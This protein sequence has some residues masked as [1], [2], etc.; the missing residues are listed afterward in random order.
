MAMGAVGVYAQKP[1][2]VE[3]KM[4]ASVE[5]H[6]EAN[7]AFLRQLV[8]INSGTQNLEGVRAVG[9]ELEPRFQAL[10]FTTHWVDQSAVHRAGHLLAEHLCPKPGTCGKRILLIGHMDTVFEKTSPF[11]HMTIE[12]SK[13]IGPGV[14]DMKGGLVVML[15]AL[16]AMQDAGVLQHAEITAVLDGDEESHG[17]PASISRATLVDAGKH[18]DVALEFEATAIQHG[19]YYGSISRRGTTS[20]KLTTSGKTGHSAGIFNAEMGDGAIYEIAR[21][22]NA[23]R[24]ELP[25]QYLTY[26]VGI[27]SGGTRVE[28]V[29]GGG[30]QAFGKGNVVPPIAEA[31]GDIRTLS[32]EQTARVEQKMR[33]IVAKHLPKTDGTIEF[34][35]G[36][37]AMPPTE[38]S[39]A[40][41]K[42]LNQVNATLGQ[43][44]MPELDPMQRGAGDIAF[45]ANLPGLA[46]VGATGWDSHAPGESADLPSQSLN[47]KRDALLMY[48]LSL[49]K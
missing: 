33:D 21:I 40:V 36:Y 13:V 43:P 46:G 20:W 4:I 44:A 49:Q 25:E 5:K 7:I 39:R 32:N 15:A 35:E 3:A 28:S 17:T 38:A 29:P 10:G 11:Q 16:Q 47:A 30:L 48:R 18:S 22:L 26:N 14:N 42:T 34:D 27:V 8:E 41:L 31:R 19:M 23:F 9:A 1:S 6:E 45:V 24:S 12:G 37:P 2:A